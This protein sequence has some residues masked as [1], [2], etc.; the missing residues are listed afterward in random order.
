MAEMGLRRP[1]RL[2]GAL[3]ALGLGSLAGPVAGAAGLPPAN[4]ASAG[5]AAFEPYTAENG[6]PLELQAVAELAEATADTGVPRC[7]GRSSLARTVWYRIA[8]TV[9]PQ[10][11]TVDASG[12]T[13]DVIDLA[14]FVQPEAALGPLTVEPNAC[15]GLGSGGAD[16]SEEPTSA[17]I[18]R[19]PA[20]R[21]LLI[22]VGRRGPVGSADNERAVLSSEVRP[23][24]F[25]FPAAG[26]IADKSTPGVRS[27]RWNRVSLAAATI[28]EEDPAQPPCPSLG[29][30]WRRILPGRSGR[31]VISVAGRVNT[32][33][34]FSGRRPKAA[35]AL[36]C[37]N[38]SGPGRLQLNVPVRRSRP[39]WIRVGTDRPPHAAEAMLRLK[40]G[41]RAVVVDGGP[42]GFDPTTGGPGGGLPAACAQAKVRRA[43]I[44]GARISSL[45]SARNRR[46]TVRVAIAVRGGSVCDVK[47]ELVGPR[48][49]IYGVTRAIRL[50]GRRVVRLRRV[51]RLVPGRYRLRVTAVSPLGKRVRVRTKVRGR[52]S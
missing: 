50:K 38:R 10:E 13:L 28:T 2:V 20:R 16:T 5:A 41:A 37:I 21:A 36:D 22:Q 14:A 42:G 3:V 6:V 52:L 17:V 40:D 48:G 25:A 32:L 4:D 1:A 44:R 23:L 7:L 26:D 8:P 45:A 43:R 27:R 12:R 15:S 24:A 29:T 46:R 33:A 30:I 35:N 19:V 47:L 49:R 31:R 11:I 34:V 39:L 9:T 18:L 51:R